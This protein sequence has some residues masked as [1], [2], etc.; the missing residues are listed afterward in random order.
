MNL[1]LP[2][3]RHITSDNYFMI[4]GIWA[5]EYR[6]PGPILDHQKES[7]FHSNFGI[8]QQEFLVHFDSIKEFLSNEHIT[9]FSFDLG[10]VAEQVVV[11]DYKYICKSPPLKY[12]E[13]KT[14]IA[15]RLEIIRQNYSGR[16]A[17]ENLNH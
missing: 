14:L 11:K 17:M 7:L 3:S 9:L 6:Q 10:P 15:Q 4:A 8:I 13:L 5:L 12:R 16:I 1:T 2:V